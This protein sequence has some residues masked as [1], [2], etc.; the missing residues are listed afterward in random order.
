[1]LCMTCFGRP[2]MTGRTCPDCGGMG[3]ADTDT[4]Q[5]DFAASDDE[6]DAAGS[7]VWLAQRVLQMQNHGAATRVPG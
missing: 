5:R 4:D 3:V 6:S 7:S 1:M 2:E